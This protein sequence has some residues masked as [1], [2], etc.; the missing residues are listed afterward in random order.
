MVLA[1]PSL[2]I[3]WQFDDYV[4][5]MILREPE[6]LPELTFSPMTFFSFVK[7]NPEELRQIMD[8]GFLPWWTQEEF[9][10]AFLRP[11]TALSHWIDHILWPNYPVLMHVHSLLWFGG[12]VLLTALLYRRVMGLVWVAGLAAFFFAIDDAHAFPASWL[13]NRNALLAAFFGLLTLLAHHRWRNK[14]WRIGVIIGPLCLLIGLLSGEAAIAT[15]AYLIS[16]AVFIDRGSWFR[17]SLGLLPYGLVTGIWWIYYNQLGYGT[18]GSGLYIDPAREPLIFSLAVLERAPILL[19]GQWAFPPSTI[20]IL[21]NKQHICIFSLCALVF[22][23]IVGYI[24]TPLLR[25][26]T[27]ACFWGLGMVLSLLPICATFPH[28]RLLI[29]V[30]IGAMGLLAQFITAKYERADW[31]PKRLLWR[32]P[33]SGLTWLFLGVHAVLAPLLLPL[34][35]W[36]PTLLEPYIQGAANSAP[37]EPGIEQQDFIIV[38]PPEP[39]FAQYLP[40]VRA[41]KKQPIP[42]HMRILASGNTHL[43]LIRPDERTLVIRPET[44]YFTAPFDRL[45]R[46]ADY[47]MTLGQKVEL[48]GMS[49]EITALTRDKRPAE[50]IF[51]FDVPLE[52]KSLRWLQWKDNAYAPFT[53][54]DIG[55]T[56]KLSA[57]TTIY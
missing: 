17:R 32:I 27:M 53:P 55:Q 57:V 34:Y 19:L 30:G 36:T 51:R 56:M 54:P 38:N 12:V 5:Q 1:A 39:F 7:D 18:Y 46:G 26:N 47:P 42:N 35:S 15:G 25:R 31:F 16:Y 28:D 11:I 41:A 2:W 48:S 6:F 14:N 4:H 52:D 40:M 20:Y 50:A 33:A 3:G 9:R 49:V 43:T 10:A 21:F 23:I 22:L 8:M 24:V 37:M 44:G 45:Y 13:A 29:F